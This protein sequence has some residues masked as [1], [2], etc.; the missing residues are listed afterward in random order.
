MPQIYERSFEVIVP[1][2]SAVC[3]NHPLITAPGD[4]GA[5]APT[6]GVLRKLVIKQLNGAL[7]GFTLNAY[8][9]RDACSSVAEISNSFDTQDLADPDLHKICAEVSVSSTNRLS[10]QYGLSNAYENLDE[11]DNRRTGNSRIYFEINA[12]GSGDK[13]F[14]IGYA[15]EPIE[16]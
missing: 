6:R 5:P 16:N 14:Q 1:S 4:G 13:T 15:I 3:V 2:G 11:Q 7:D 8:N 10:A 9:R 12:S